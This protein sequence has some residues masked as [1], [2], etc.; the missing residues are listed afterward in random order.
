MN[1][2]ITIE[3]ILAI[4]FARFPLTTGSLSVPFKDQTPN[5]FVLYG[6]TVTGYTLINFNEFPAYAEMLALK[7]SV[8]AAIDP[9]N[10]LRLELD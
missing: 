2:L 3:N 5:V 8:I 4:V 10:N 9:D 1:P 6:D 7:G